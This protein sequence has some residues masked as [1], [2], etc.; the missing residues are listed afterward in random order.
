M[1]D[2][3]TPEPLMAIWEQHR[4]RILSYGYALHGLLPDG[5]PP[6]TLHGR[7]MRAGDEGVGFHFQ[8]TLIDNLYD[9]EIASACFAVQIE[10]IQADPVSVR[11]DAVPLL[12]HGD[13]HYEMIGRRNTSI[14]VD[15]HRR[16]WLLFA[17]SLRA[18]ATEFFSLVRSGEPFDDKLEG[19]SRPEQHHR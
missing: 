4:N 14:P 18:S 5:M 16:Q 17:Y 6:V 13:G 1:T 11:I 10:L 19:F 9:G 12:E 2:H 8:Y 15:D 7:D 3:H